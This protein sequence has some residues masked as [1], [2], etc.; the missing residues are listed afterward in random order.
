MNKNNRN[1]HRQRVLQ[2]VWP[3]STQ[4][5]LTTQRAKGPFQVAVTEP[6]RGHMCA[7]HPVLSS[8]I[9]HEEAEAQ[10]KSQDWSEMPLWGRGR[11]NKQ[12]PALAVTAA[13]GG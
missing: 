7:R 11:D 9:F 12:P 10:N 13:R 3:S 2:S 8:P 1:E 4:R 5:A 6:G